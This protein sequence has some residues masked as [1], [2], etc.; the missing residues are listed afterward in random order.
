MKNAVE[1][2]M[3]LYLQYFCHFLNKYLPGSTISALCF[4]GMSRHAVFHLQQH[5]ERW[6]AP[7]AEGAELC[8]SGSI[9]SYKG[10]AGSLEKVSVRMHSKG[11]FIHHTWQ[12]GRGK[13]LF[14]QHWLKSIHTF[15]FWF[16]KM[17]K[18]QDNCRVLKGTHR[19]ILKWLY[20]PKLT[21][22]IIFWNE[23]HFH[24]CES[25]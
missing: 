10:P 18:R 16:L 4:G 20:F 8:L 15:V 23:G 3:L 14:F 25:C 11:S 2:S 17:Y 6:T 22:K 19:H 5:L 21:L 7:S 24:S 12:A 13:T 9:S 1:T